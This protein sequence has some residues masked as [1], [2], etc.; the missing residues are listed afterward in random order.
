M[1]LANRFQWVSVLK[2]DD[3]FRLL[4]ATYNY[5]WS[6]DSNHL[7]T[8]LLEPIPKSQPTIRPLNRPGDR[9]T[10]FVS[11]TNE[12]RTI[13]RSFNSARGCN[14]SNCVYKHACNRRV[15]GG[16]ACGQNH[17]GYSHGSHTSQPQ[18]QAIKSTQQ[19]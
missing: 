9:N 5:P 8:V 14:F 12:G 7:H 18:Q 13:C 6:F 3:E 16:K 1:E 4:R 11:T 17:P 10:S 19:S 2:Y 15:T